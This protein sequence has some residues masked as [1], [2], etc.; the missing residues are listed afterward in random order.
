MSGGMTLVYGVFTPYNCSMF[1]SPEKFVLKESN[2]GRKWG[3]LSLL[4]DAPIAYI[5]AR[6]AEGG[7]PSLHPSVLAQNLRHATANLPHRLIPFIISSLLARD[8]LTNE[9]C[10]QIATFFGLN[11][12]FDPANR[13]GEFFQ[14]QL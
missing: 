1:G 11:H 12:V 10:E 4:Y 2:D 3:H 9:G 7:N 8:G 14:T 13:L 6:R 5:L